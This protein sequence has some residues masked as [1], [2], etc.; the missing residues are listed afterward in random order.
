MRHILFLKRLMKSDIYSRDGESFLTERSRHN[1]MICSHQKQAMR[2]L[3]SNDTCWSR[4]AQ[5]HCKNSIH[6][7]SLARWDVSKD[8]HEESMFSALQRRIPGDW[9]RRQQRLWSDCRDTS[10]AMIYRWNQWNHDSHWACRILQCTWMTLKRV[11]CWMYSKKARDS[12]AD[13]ERCRSRTRIVFISTITFPHMK[14]IEISDELF[15]QIEEISK[16]MNSRNH[17]WTAM[18]Y[19]WTIREKKMVSSDDDACDFLIISEDWE[20]WLSSDSKESDFHKYIRENDLKSQYTEW[21]IDSHCIWK[22]DQDE[23]IEFL[24]EECWC[25]KWW[26]QYI[27]TYKNSFFTYEACMNHIK[28]NH[29]HYTEPTPY[30]FHAW[31]NPEMEAIQELICEISWWKIHK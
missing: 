9:R 26:Y 30:L 21:R 3:D 5:S 29:Y 25:H 6:L 31:R 13:E 2:V 8:S 12:R 1:L 20:T 17:L 15:S 28:S 18:P 24:E 14:T 19:F 11:R 22:A 7:E 16:R 23:L 10:E 4:E 27:D